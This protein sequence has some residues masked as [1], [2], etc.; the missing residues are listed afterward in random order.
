MDKWVIKEKNKIKKAILICIYFLYKQE[1]RTKKRI[2]KMDFNV[3]ISAGTFSV[4]GQTYELKEAGI[5]NPYRYSDEEIINL[6]EG[7]DL[8]SLTPLENDTFT[9]S[10]SSVE[11]SDKSADELEEMKAELEEER[12]ENYEKM[13]ALEAQIEELIEK[14]EDLAEAAENE[15]KEQTEA[16]EEDSKAAVKEQMQAYVEA[17]KNGEGMTREELQNNITNALPNNPNM[18][19]IFNSLA[20][21]N[22]ILDEVDTYVLNLRSLIEDT[23]SIEDQIS[24]LDNNIEVAKAAEEE[25]QAANNCCDPI[26]FEYE[27]A[28]YDFIVQDEDGFNS[29]SDFLGAEDQWAAMQALDTDQDGTVNYEE[30]KA[31]NIQLV[32]T[33][34]DAQSVVDIA[35]VFGEDFSIDLN[36]Y[37]S[38]DEGAEYA[39]IDTG[40]HDNDGTVNQELLGTFSLNIGDETIEGYNTLDDTE[41][42]SETYG[43]DAAVADDEEATSTYSEA[44][45]AHVTLAELYEQKSESLREQ[46]NEDYELFDLSEDEI[47]EFDSILQAEAD[48]EASEFM[49]TLNANQADEAE[50]VEVVEEEEEE[51]LK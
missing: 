36:T 1:I 45:Q 10:T 49:A 39:G 32:K 26:G 5:D 8:S 40:D 21:A 43:I 3:N 9:N 50:E 25:A 29:T 7:V 46:L 51:E 17:N 6:L 28:T 31:G 30:L 13:E 20:E 27:G 16:Y 12:D 38:V 18:A 22:G 34:G 2:N 44:L 24:A 15:Q 23:R 14:A 47:A 37:K 11:V 41:W 48:K 33:E 4:N 42:L 35:D 19:N